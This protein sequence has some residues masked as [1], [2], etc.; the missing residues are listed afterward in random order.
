M[1]QKRTGDLATW[2][3][4]EM[5]EADVPFLVDPEILAA[6]GLD[7]DGFM[8]TRGNMTGWMLD[9]GKHQDIIRRVQSMVATPTETRN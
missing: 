5:R 6:F 9:R 7:P 3:E 8:E 1:A 2:T 4:D